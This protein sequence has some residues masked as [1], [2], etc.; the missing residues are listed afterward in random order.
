[1]NIQD[2]TVKSGEASRLLAAMSNQQRLRILCELHQGERSVTSLGRA[3]GLSQ[4]ALSQHLAKLRAAGIV[5]T[6]RQAQT[7]HYSVS[8]ERA[9]RLLAVLYDLFCTR[10]TVAK[11]R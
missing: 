4:S 2:L 5:T 8:D 6:R 3:I 1:M 7:I 10:K 11:A 9:A